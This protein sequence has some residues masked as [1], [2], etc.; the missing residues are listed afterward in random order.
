M[1]SL[2][3]L[4]ALYRRL[5]WEADMR[6]SSLARQSGTPEGTVARHLNGERGIGDNARDRYDPVLALGTR[7]EEEQLVAYLLAQLAPRGPLATLADELGRVVFFA[8]RPLADLTA[9]LLVEADP[10]L[11]GVVPVPVWP[12][13]LGTYAAGRGADVALLDTPEAIGAFLGGGARGEDRQAA[14]VAQENA[15]PAAVARPR[16]DV[17]R[18]VLVRRAL[19]GDERHAGTSTSTVCR[20]VA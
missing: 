6:T 11:R 14:V 4:L 17:E 7:V 18:R 3:L 9:D 15:R 20:S 12:S 1:P 2:P 5:K 13:W 19:A 8:R 16:Q 10:R